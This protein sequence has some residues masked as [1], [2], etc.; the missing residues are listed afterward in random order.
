M[1]TQVVRFVPHGL[2]SPEVQARIALG[3][4]YALAANERINARLTPHIAKFN[5]RIN[6]L[7]R[8]RR[9]ADFCIPA[10]WAI[11]DEMMA[12]NAPDVACKRGCNHCCHTQVLVTTEEARVIGQRIGRKPERVAAPGR[13]R[14]DIDKFDF[15]YHNPCTFLIGGECSIYENRPLPCRTQYSLDVD[16]LMC[17]LTPHESKPVLYLNPHPF[18][19]AFLQMLGVPHVVPVLGD[20]R[21]FFPRADA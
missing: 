18:L 7:M 15:G 8:S 20:I 10:F 17:E 2:N 6:A 3:D 19:M 9:N 1:E 12:F 14:A 4:A 5:A 21:D 13:T 11:V 16:A